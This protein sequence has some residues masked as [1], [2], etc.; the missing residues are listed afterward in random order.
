MVEFV[1][2]NN[3][4]EFNG[5]VKKQLLGTAIGT[6]FAPTYASIFMDKLESGFLKSWELTPLLWYCYIDDVFFIWTH[7]EEKLASFL[8]VLNN[9]HPNIKFTH[10][11]NKEH[12]PFLELNMKLLGNK[13]STNLYI[14]STDR[15][16]YLHYVSSHPDHPKK[17]VVY[18]QALKLSR[19][20]SEEKK[21]E[22]HICEMDSRKNS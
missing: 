19:I 9:Y 3:Y 4:F 17:S 7:G 20:C 6:T 13:L 5:K 18:S 1:L 15:H 22:E 16:Q 12:I 14:K 10:E 2:K 21:I 11:S 8:N